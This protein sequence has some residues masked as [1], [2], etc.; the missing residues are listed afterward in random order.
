VLFA[1]DAGGF[2]HAVTA[3]GIYYAMVSGALAAQALADTRGRGVAAA[4]RLY[5]RRWRAEI[6]QELRDAVRLQQYLFASPQRVARAIRGAGSRP[7]LTT[8][9]LAYAAGERTYHSLRRQLLL[10][11]PMTALRLARARF[12]GAATS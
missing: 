10:R 2:V 4:A 3:E 1:G 11:F 7:A 12:A 8:L 9:V 5:E 6:G